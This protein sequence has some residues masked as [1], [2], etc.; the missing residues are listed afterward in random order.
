LLQ[1]LNEGLASG[2]LL[3]LISA[4]AGYGKS[5]LAAEWVAQVDRPVAWLSL[6][7]ADDEALRFWTYFLAALQS[8]KPG[9]G[10]ESAAALAAGQLPPQEALLGEL[11]NGLSALEQPCLCV[12]DDFHHIQDPAVLNLLQG[13]LAHQ[14]PQFHLAL[15]TREDPPLPLARLRAQR[16]LTDVRLA[17][18][19][20]SSSEIE[21]FL[22]SVMGLEL[23]AQQLAHLEERTEGWISGLQ[24]AGLAMQSA[25]ASSGRDAVAKLIESLSGGHRFF[26]AYLTEEVL[27]LQPVEV[28]DFLLRTSILSKMTGELCEAV[29]GMPAGAARLEAMLA[30]NLFII[31]LDSE[32]SWYRYH[33][34]FAELL[35]TQLR[36]HHAMELPELHQ[37]ASRWFEMQQMP[38]EALEH[39]LAAG[40][41]L[42]AVDLLEK[43]AWSLL[44]Q[45]YVRKVEAWVG[46]IPPEL[47]ASSP[48]AY[49]DFA[50]MHMLRG[51]FRHVPPYL[52]QAEAAVRSLT[53]DAHETLNLQA[54]CLALQSNLLQTQGDPAG[55]LQAAKQ[56]L[57]LASPDNVRVTGLAWLGYGAAQRTRG[58][59]DEA[60]AALRQ[61]V[62]ASQRSGDVVTGMLA[63]SHLTLM[64]LQYG[65]LRLA[66]EVALQSLAHLEAAGGP[67]PPIVGAGYGALG[68]IY[69]EWNRLDEA[70]QHLLEGIRLGAYSG[71]NA[72]VIYSKTT[73]ARLHQAEGDLEAAVRL[74]EEA[75]ALFE[76]GAPGWVRPGL[77]AC[78]VRLRLAQGD[79]AAAEALLLQ[80]GVA[81]GDEITHQTDAIHLAWLRLMSARKD[82]AALA[83]AQRLRASAQAGHRDGTLLQTL[84]LGA[85]IQAGKP[86]AARSWLEPAL[87][88][89]R[90]ESYWRVLLDEG[91]PL[92]AL[93]QRL[94][95][96]SLLALFPGV[97]SAERRS[98]DAPEQRLQP[99]I[100]PLS[101][102]ELEVL[103]LL[104]AGLTYDEIAEKLVVSLNTV[105]F[106]VKSIYGK[107]GVDKR[108]RAIQAAREAGLL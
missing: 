75:A 88:L 101:E 37:R 87:D 36:R 53:P 63:V 57:Q 78:Q 24:L 13:L 11:V 42:H 105:R 97:V 15:V 29:T 84:V 45:G 9:L 50:W 82:A 6:E 85:L 92:A 47:L 95:E 7:E 100:E 31:P 51:G 67:L 80:S 60:F 58:N 68:Q 43:H 73:L 30:A 5:T 18:L 14:P 56:A 69:Y 106:H 21:Q 32:G 22:H 61:A 46:L 1:R 20:F 107:L 40:D 4:P 86:E 102:R 83:L 19:R 55:S 35:S 33:H 23:S 72:S 16:L 91:A 3:T 74:L 93:L 26:L 96:T 66:A 103:R 94:G 10:A 12:L 17:E 98:V 90:Q 77:L 89:A 71:H 64:A 44:N 65:R 104:A 2:S 28:Q 70:R 99:L 76:R 8:L 108:A 38:S 49:L 62:A 79:L 81:A 27:K 52:L 34:L 48:R 59:F 39:A 25:A 54:E 41:Y